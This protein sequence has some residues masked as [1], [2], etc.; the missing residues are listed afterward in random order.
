MWQYTPYTIPLA[1]TALMAA[2]GAALAW[3]QREGPTELWSAIV[4]LSIVLWSVVHLLTVSSTAREHKLLWLSLVFPT[5]ALLV[6]SVLC[7]TLHFTGRGHWLTRPRVAALLAFPAVIAVVSLA[8]GVRGLF[9]VDPSVDASGPFALLVYEWGPGFYAFLAVVYAIVAV[10]I[11]L[12]VRKLLR[13]RNVYRSVSFAIVVPIVVMTGGT[14]LSA[15]QRSPVPHFLQFPLLYLLF[16]LLAIP[17]TASTRVARALPVDRLFA[18]VGSRVGSVVPLA[19]DFIVEEVDSGILVLDADGRIVDVNS[20]AKKMLGDERPVG[21]HVTDIVQ[22]D[23]VLE[24]D[25]LGDALE[26]ECELDDLRDEV[27]VATD[28][29]DRCYEVAV[30]TLTDDGSSVGHVVLLHDV[31]ERK[32]REETLREREAEL[33]R[34]KVDLE[35]RTKQL[36]HQNERLDRF[37]GIVSH[38]LRNPLNV[39]QGYLGT[40]SVDDDAETVEVDAE[41][42]EALQESHDRMQDIIDDALTMARQGKAITDPQRV[43]LSATAADAW[44]NVETATA[45]LAIRG[46][47]TIRADRDRLLTLFENLF[48]NSIEH[49]HDPADPVTVTVGTLPNGFYVEDDGPGIPDERRDEVL[50]H[51]VTTSD[52]GTGFGLTI[53]GDVAS[54]HGW[55]LE[56]A[57]GDDGGLRVVLTDV[58]VLRSHE[59]NAAD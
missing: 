5:I 6:V 38:D 28:Q 2:S 16:G 33:E 45:E 1:L 30:S 34:Q 26:G 4:Q 10:Y 55:E 29:G 15:T 46:D 42:I 52:D 27:W 44:S 35:T 59:S 40:V 53:V 13:S 18:A 37:A 14:I 48:R 58:S 7:F 54:A 9:L 41:T 24:W 21:K 32:R 25:A 49:A 39:A 47:A 57:D 50:E 3:R 51:G 11:W 36:E 19:R 22:R 17:A 20:V 8:G 12:L 23:R 31:T 56:L 43:E